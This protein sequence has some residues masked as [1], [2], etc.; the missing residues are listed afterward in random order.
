M[1][2]SSDSTPLAAEFRH[3]SSEL[4]LYSQRYVQPDR[5]PNALHYHDC[6]ELGR[7]TAGSGVMMID[8]RTYTFAPGSVT[9]IPCG[10]IHDSHIPTQ[11]GGEGSGWEFVFTDPAAFGIRCGERGGFLTADAEISALFGMLFTEAQTRPPLW[12][13]RI[14]HLLGALLFAAERIAPVPSVGIGTALPGEMAYA[15]RRIT[16]CYDQPLSME[17]LARE[18]CMSVSTFGRMFR[19]TMGT[20]PLAFLRSIRLTVAC[21]L[22]LHTDRSILEI[23]GEAG[24]ATLSSFNRAFRAERGA[25]PREY[26]RQM[27]DKA[28]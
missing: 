4:P 19:R 10:C 8:H 25:S 26:R 21:H 13:E 24:F 14:P 5:A 17:E 11:G 1:Q 20:T 27:R 28:Y 18:C 23:A 3:L 7:C 22:L 2:F 16:A 12:R 15:L 6:L 9:V